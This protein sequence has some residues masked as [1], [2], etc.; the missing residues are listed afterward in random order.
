MAF[1]SYMLY[2]ELCYK[3]KANYLKWKHK[4]IGAKSSFLIILH[5]TAS[6]DAYWW[7][8]NQHVY[9][10]AR[11]SNCTWRITY[12]LVVPRRRHPFEGNPFLYTW[13]TSFIKNSYQQQLVPDRRTLR[14]VRVFL[15]RF[16]R[17]TCWKNHL[18]RRWFCRSASDHQA[19][20]HAP[21]STTPNKHFQSELRLGQRGLK[22]TRAAKKEK[23][24]NNE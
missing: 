10:T 7:Q 13:K 6:L 9:N 5:F 19:E 22:Y 3:L 18:H 11:I 2:C 1:F 14:V 23:N 8:L 16:Q 20:F 24:T 17:R 21:S 15:H 4:T 12:S